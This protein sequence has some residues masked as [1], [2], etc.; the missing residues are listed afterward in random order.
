MNVKLSV[1]FG[2]KEVYC[3]DTVVLI[4]LFWCYW[5]VKDYNVVSTISR[6]YIETLS[7][8]AVK[9]YQSADFCFPFCRNRSIKWMWHQLTE[10]IIYCPVRNVAAISVC[11]S[12]CLSVRL[13]V[14]SLLCRLLC[15]F[16]LGNG[17]L[18]SQHDDHNLI[19]RM[20]FLSYSKC[21]SS[22]FSLCYM[23]LMRFVIILS[24]LVR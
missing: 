2:K 22:I 18:N 21:S 19:H 9:R 7:D 5:C 4:V 10:R 8:K 15:R 20:L 24:R 13:S 3:C 23:F 12:V 17:K 14:F 16:Y 6:P 1:K 11:R